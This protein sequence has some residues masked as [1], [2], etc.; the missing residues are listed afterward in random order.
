MKVKI[1][2]CARCGG[3]HEDLEFAEL[4][5]PMVEAKHTHWAM[6][7]TVNEPIMLRIVEE[8]TKRGS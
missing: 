8:H 5:R 3:T 2:N 7:P 4:S 1:S 6:C